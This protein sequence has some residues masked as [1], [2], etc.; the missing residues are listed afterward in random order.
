MFIVSLPIEDRARSHGFYRAIGLHPVGPL[1]ED[2]LPEPL[3]FDLAEGARLMLIPQGGF[4]WVTGGR[5]L[6]PRGS[7]ECLLSLSATS[8]EA[9]QDLVRRAQE[10]GAELISKPEHQPWGYTAVFA[11]PDGHAWMITVAP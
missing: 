7:T 4:G 11:D 10:A 9:L 2:G 8:E 6:A 1:A 3:Q 5:P